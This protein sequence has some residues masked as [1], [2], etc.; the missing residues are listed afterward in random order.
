MRVHSSALC[1]SCSSIFGGSAVCVYSMASIRAAFNGPFAHKEG[2]DHR[3]VEYKGRIPY[4]RPGAVS[5]DPDGFSVVFGCTCGNGVYLEN[6][7]TVLKGSFTQNTQSADD[8][9][10]T[11]GVQYGGPEGQFTSTNHSQQ[12]LKD[13]NVKSKT[14]KKAALHFIFKPINIPPKP[15]NQSLHHSTALCFSSS[16]LSVSVP[17]RP[18]TLSTSPPRTSQT[19]W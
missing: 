14:F 6:S 1:F 10:G 7:S 4:P 16:S 13:Y 9:S 2:P 11:I 8:G 19:R 18:T 5:A 17:V 12:H 3:W 15:T